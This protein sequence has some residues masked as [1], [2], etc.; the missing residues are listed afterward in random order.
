MRQLTYIS[1]IP[2][3]LTQACEQVDVRMQ[4]GQFLDLQRSGQAVN[5]D[6]LRIL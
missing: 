2:L 4:H 5:H 1:Q 3:L 6:Y